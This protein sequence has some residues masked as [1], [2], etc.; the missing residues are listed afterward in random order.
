MTI[1][2]VNNNYSDLRRFH[3]S[4]GTIIS[5]SHHSSSSSEWARICALE[6]YCAPAAHGSGQGAVYSGIS[7]VR[8]SCTGIVLAEVVCTEAT[9]CSHPIVVCLMPAR[10][11]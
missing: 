7:A 4:H 6:Q 2:H 9:V 1:T 3:Q 8:Q 11:S 10:E 5:N